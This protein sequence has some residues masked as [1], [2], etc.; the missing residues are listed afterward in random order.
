MFGCLV[1]LYE[2]LT[3]NSHVNINGFRHA[4]I[5]TALGLLDYDTELVNY[6][7]M[8]TESDYDLSDDQQSQGE[9]TDSKV[10][11]S[12]EDQTVYTKVP[13]SV[14]NIFMYTEDSD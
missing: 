8:S 4:G 14:E 9:C 10:E 2:H 5:F 3:N 6:G 1:A 12:H 13:L 11:L 7:E